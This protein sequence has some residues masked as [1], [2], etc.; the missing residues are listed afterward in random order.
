MDDRTREIE[1]AT[2]AASLGRL[3][4][5]VA[6][7]AI[8]CKVGRPLDD[9]DRDALEI[10]A[11]MLDDIAS[12][13]STAVAPTPALLHTMSAPVGVV[14]EAVDAVTSASESDTAHFDEWLRELA[15]DLRTMREGNADD[16]VSGRV[17]SFF[18]RLSKITL[19]RAAQLAS[20]RTGDESW[21][22][23]ALNYLTS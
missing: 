15:G 8:R 1:A 18:D 11:A 12:F 20:R 21:T 3:A 4:D 9:T 6:L 14:D 5:Q 22:Q 7:A 13:R 19:A 16:A 2:G 10:A 17:H 23:E